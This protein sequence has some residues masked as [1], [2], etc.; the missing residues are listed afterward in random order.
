[1]P[2]GSDVTT[3]TR[4]ITA[5]FAKLYPPDGEGKICWGRLKKSSRDWLQ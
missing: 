2:P 3:G 1:M 5:S 4:R